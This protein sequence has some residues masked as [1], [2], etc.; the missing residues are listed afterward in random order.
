MYKKKNKFMALALVAITTTTMLAGCTS[1]KEAKQTMYRQYGINSLETGEYKEAVKSFQKALN[2]SGGKV[3]DGEVDIC[4]YKAESQ[5]LSGDKKGAINTYSAIIDFNNNAKAYCLR[6]DVYM[7]QG[8]EKKALKDYNE[9]I[10]EDENNYDIY[11]EIYNTLKEYGSKVSGKKY[12]DKALKID[13]NKAEDK[14][15]KARIYNILGKQKKAISLLNEAIKD[16]CNDAY[17]YLGE[18]Y[19]ST[20]KKADV[21]KANKNFK[22][23]M[24]ESK[25]DSLGYYKYG[26]ILMKNKEYNYALSYF[27]NGLKEDE[28]PNKQALMKQAIAAYEYTGDF[29]S[30][31]ELM[32]KYMENY[33]SDKSA[34]TEYTFLKTR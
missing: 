8:N 12:L 28:I 15:Q 26:K 9:A 13:S 11:I 20:G 10:K 1:K 21:D 27:L 16:K 5:Y 18:I 19:A 25:F 17:F 22:K 31:K 14:T 33:P 7:S 23:H 2:Q 6:G 29:K 4:F 24:E 34:K 32:K 30:A 3:K